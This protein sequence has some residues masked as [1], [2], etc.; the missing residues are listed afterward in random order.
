MSYTVA[1]SEKLR[2]S[3]SETETKAML[4]L[5][6]FREDSDEIYY[7]VVD[8]FND[9]TGM[10]RI[11]NKLWD[12]QS[13]GS[14]TSSPKAIGEELVTLFKNYISD[15]TFNCFILFLGGVTS[16]LRIDQTKTAFGIDNINPTAL[17]KLREGLMAECI[18][19]IYIKNEMITEE[20]ISGFLNKILF[21]VDDKEP[22][23]YVKAI[24]KVHPHVIPE[25]Q[26]LDAIFNEI[27][28][29]QASKKNIS[30]VEGIVIETTDEVLGYYRHLTSS[31]IR[32]VV[33][34]RIINR[35]PIE[36]SIPL[37]FLEIMNKCPPERRKDML[38]D[39]QGALC[40]ALFNKNAAT[41]FWTLF[42]NVYNLI[43]KNPDAN[44]QGVYNQLDT[45]LID[46]C[47][48]FDVI[49]IKYFIAIV[50]DGI[51]S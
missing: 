25:K 27:R 37:P 29:E 35:N 9:M 45:S 16:T 23:E 26:I 49:S 8:F 12:V 41:S 33:L 28:D 30:S 50:K 20:N 47:P 44:V 13:K 5:M 11:A 15:L 43:I 3:A 21:I 51:Q 36:S 24:I 32:L 2:H 48:D 18:A 4:Y 42:E 1:S 38:D 34:Q 6:S 39:C 31:E 40:R 19:K 10:N 46:S 14:K 22:S 17:L 7:F